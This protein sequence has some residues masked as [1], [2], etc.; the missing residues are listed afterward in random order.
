MPNKFVRFEIKPREGVDE[1]QIE[2]AIKSALKDLGEVKDFYIGDD[3]PPP[4]PPR[5]PR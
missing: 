1:V 4:Q 3:Q 5:P 2:N